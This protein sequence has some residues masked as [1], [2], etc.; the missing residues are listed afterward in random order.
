MR[1]L[2]PKGDERLTIIGGHMTIKKGLCQRQSRAKGS[3]LSKAGSRMRIRLPALDAI[4]TA[5]SSFG[6]EIDA[7]LTDLGSRALAG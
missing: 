1:V 6:P 2:P 4:R 3:G 5:V 7:I